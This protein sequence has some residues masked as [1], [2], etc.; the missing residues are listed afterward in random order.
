MMSAF[1]FISIPLLSS[2]LDS[3]YPLEN[4]DSHRIFPLHANY[5]FF[6]GVNHFYAVSTHTAIVMYFVM[7]LYIAHDSFFLIAAGHICGLLAIVRYLSL[8]IF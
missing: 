3:I 4:G 6:D 5:I 8:Y 2:M 7:C 1:T